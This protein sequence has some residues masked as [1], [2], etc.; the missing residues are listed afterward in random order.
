MHLRIIT[1]FVATVLVVVGVDFALSRPRPVGQLT[2]TDLQTITNVIRGEIAE[3][4]TDIR[5][6][7]TV[8]VID[9]GRNGVCYHCFF[10]ERT[11]KGWKV[12]WRGT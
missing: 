7:D 6:R 8:V 5:P 10:V 4:I 11:W 12:T 9:T 2:V 3:E 1:T